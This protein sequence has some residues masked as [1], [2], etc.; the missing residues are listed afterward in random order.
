MKV[1]Q[2]ID[3]GTIRVHRY[4]NSVHVTDLTNAGKRGKQVDTFSVSHRGVSD[5]DPVVVK[6]MDRVSSTLA[7]QTNYRTALQIVEDYIAR[8]PR[9]LGIYKRQAR[10]ID[11]RPGGIE[12]IVARSA[13]GI[14]LVAE[15]LEFRLAHRDGF[16]DTSY[17]SF[18]KADARK[19]YDW[20]LANREKFD[21]MG[22]RDFKRVWQQL[23]IRYNSH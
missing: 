13:F 15:P 3:S 17:W 10:G 2:T 23:G 1:G 7:E 18:K 8:Y 11:V 6:R 22:I 21:S 19:F 16:Q 14:D 4:T 9:E 12:K 20:L 5:Y